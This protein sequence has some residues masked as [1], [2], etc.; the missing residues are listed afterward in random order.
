LS[1]GVAVAGAALFTCVQPIVRAFID[2]AAAVTSSQRFQRII[3]I[4]G[5]CIAVT[6]TIS[7]GFQAVGKKVQPTMLSLLRKGGWTC[8]SCF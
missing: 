2:N 7:T 4:T 3:R 1:L 8:P 5:P 6:L